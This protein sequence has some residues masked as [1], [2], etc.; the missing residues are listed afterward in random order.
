MDQNTTP[1]AIKQETLAQLETIINRGSETVLT[2]VLEDDRFID[3]LADRIVHKLAGAER[4]PVQ[5]DMRY[6]EV[7][8]TEGP[9]SENSFRVYVETAV[10]PTNPRGIH[11]ISEDGSPVELR[12][13]VVAAI[14]AKLDS[15]DFTGGKVYW[16]T[17]TYVSSAPEEQG[18]VAHGE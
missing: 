5:E 11:P 16:I 18:E 15:G 14:K 2:R 17:L 13:D 6:W 4:A 8:I 10:H 7:D 9:L 12:E 3:R 1:T